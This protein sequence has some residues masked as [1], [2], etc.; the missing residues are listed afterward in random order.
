MESLYFIAGTDEASIDTARAAMGRH[1]RGVFEPF[2]EQ[3]AID[4]TKLPGYE[5]VKL[6][7]IRPNTRRSMTA[8]L[9]TLEGAAWHTFGAALQHVATMRARQGVEPRALFAV[10]DFTEV[11]INRIA[12]GSLSG[13]EAQVL[14]VIIARRICDSGRQI[15]V[16]AFQ[17]AHLE[18]RKELEHL[19]GQ[20]SAP[21]LP[22]LPGVLVLPIVGAISAARGQQIVDALL[23]GIG[24]HDAHTA[25]LDITGITDADATLP[26][27]LQRATSAVRLL[28][29]RL[30]LAGVR[31]QVASMLAEHAGGLRGVEVHATL[32]DALVAA[33]PATGGRPWRAARRP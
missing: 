15:V 17:A 4:T 23:A 26:T 6:E 16:D 25:I 30:V 24:H 29:A 7:Q 2:V 28:G 13:P 12:V 10:L 9:A 11:L 3:A 31:P 22:A 20:F 5:S 14:G 21:I 33:A 27:H 1:F 18:A 8:I 19:A 32:A